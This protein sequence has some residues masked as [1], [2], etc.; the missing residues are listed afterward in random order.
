[1]SWKTI[2]L[3]ALFCCAVALALIFGRD[4]RKNGADAPV[5]QNSDF[6][7]QDFTITRF[8]ENGDKSSVIVG[9]KLTRSIDSGTSFITRPNA[10]LFSDGDA[11]WQVSSAAGTIDK[12]HSNMQLNGNVVATRREDV[13]IT[14]ETESLSL[15]L[16]AE[17][18]QTTD[19]VTVR[20]EGG[21]QSGKG[22]RAEL[23]ANQL[24]ILSEV[25]AHYEKTR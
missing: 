1:M 22:M 25:K 6:Y 14:A 12:T 4:E 8:D 13:V 23:T 7:M 3:L 15:D 5:D 11:L 10:R 16:V 19:E 2:L 24:W 18:A 17:T 9:E 21:V 20:H